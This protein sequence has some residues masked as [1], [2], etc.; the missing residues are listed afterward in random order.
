MR[1]KEMDDEDI[2]DKI[3]KEQV[4]LAANKVKDEKVL[5]IDDNQLNSFEQHGITLRMRSIN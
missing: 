3:L 1:Y 4:D 2:V 5:D